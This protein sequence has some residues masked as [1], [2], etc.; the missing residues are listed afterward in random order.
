MLGQVAIAEIQ[1]SQVRRWRKQLLD[2]GVSEVTAA[3]AYRLLKAILNTALD[4]GVI[5]R[6][7]C[8]IKGAGQEKSAERPTLTIAQVYALADAVGQRYRA[9]ILLAMFLACAGASWPRCVGAMSTW[10]RA[11]SGWSGSS[12]RSTAWGSCTGRRSRRR[13]SV[14]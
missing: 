2:A 7:P 5:R 13:A 3:K 4:D 14:S 10:R 9:L 11:P 12:A 6:N 8:R 1:P